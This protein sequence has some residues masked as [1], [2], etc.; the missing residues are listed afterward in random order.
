VRYLILLLLSGCATTDY[1]KVQWHRI[2]NEPTYRFD[3][4]LG[5]SSATKANGFSRNVDGVCHIWAPDPPVT[6]VD[7]KRVFKQ[8]QWGTL[9]H[10]LKHCFDGAFHD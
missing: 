6:V 10:E 5:H 3:K 7:G 9:G 8:G 2:P 1:V 4:R